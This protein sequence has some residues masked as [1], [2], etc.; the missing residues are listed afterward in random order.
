MFWFLHATAAVEYWCLA[1]IVCFSG[2][3]CICSPISIQTTS[4][5]LVLLRPSLVDV[6]VT[7]VVFTV[8]YLQTGGIFSS[9]CLF[10]Q[11]LRWK[12]VSIVKLIHSKYFPLTTDK[13]YKELIT[14]ITPITFSITALFMTHLNLPRKTFNAVLYDSEHWWRKQRH[15]PWKMLFGSVRPVSTF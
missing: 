10:V 7:C 14:E 9:Y 6:D 3:W 5:L 12:C 2:Q 1:D 11:L 15:S 13:V 8:Q 4:V